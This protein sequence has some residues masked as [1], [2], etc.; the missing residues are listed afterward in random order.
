MK[1][2]SKSA[3]STIAQKR[4]FRVASR[5]LTCAPTPRLVPI[6]SPPARSPIPPA[7]STSTAEY[8]RSVRIALARTSN[9]LQHSQPSENEYT[10]TDP[11]RRHVHQVCSNRESDDKHRVTP[12]RI[13]CT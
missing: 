2:P 12:R 3:S 11:Q 1:P 7:Q 9:R 13:L 4:K 10:D 6:S 8:I 5:C